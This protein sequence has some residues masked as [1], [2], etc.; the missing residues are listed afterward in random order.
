MLLTKT[1]PSSCSRISFSTASA[2]PLVAF[3]AKQL[4]T[5]VAA[6]S[7][8]TV[9]VAVGNLLVAIRRL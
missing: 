5:E 6:D 1:D 2:A 8:S 7:S 4:A 3:S 9:V